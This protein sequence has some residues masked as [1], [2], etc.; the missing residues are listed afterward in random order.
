MELHLGVMVVLAVM[1]CDALW[2]KDSWPSD[3]YSMHE[4]VPLQLFR[5]K[6]LHFFITIVLK[7]PLK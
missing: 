7:S 6:R 2:L 4:E 5:V 1:P 3:Y